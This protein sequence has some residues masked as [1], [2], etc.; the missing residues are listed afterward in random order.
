MKLQGKR[1]KVILLCTGNPPQGGN[2]KIT[3]IPTKIFHPP[4][5]KINRLD[6]QKQKKSKP[7]QRSPLACFTEEDS[8]C[9]LGEN[10]HVVKDILWI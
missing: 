7:G 6:M 1:L 9:C 10:P 4:P 2:G 3:M 8:D 5:K